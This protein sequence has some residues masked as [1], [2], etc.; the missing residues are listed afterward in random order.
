MGAF[1]FKMYVQ[2]E[3]EQVR[4]VGSCVGNKREW[5]DEKRNE[6]KWVSKRTVVDEIFRL[7]KKLFTNR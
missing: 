1:L 7:E 6:K 3:I 4:I 2:L 5:N